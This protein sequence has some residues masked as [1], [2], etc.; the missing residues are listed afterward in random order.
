MKDKNLMGKVRKSSLQSDSR[1]DSLAG[2]RA[3]AAIGIALMHYLANMDESMEQALKE[4]SCLYET[5]IPFFTLFVYMFF[6]LSA[7]SM[8]CGYYNKF[9]VKD[10]KSYFD[11]ERFY[12]KRYCRIW[13]F[14]ALLVCID[15]LMNPSLEEIYEAF[16]DLTLVFNLLPNPEI[17]VI[18]V[19]WFLG[20]I[21]VF[22]MIFPWFIFLLKDKRRAWFAM[23]IALVMHILVREYFLT[24]KFVLESEI[25]CARHNIVFSFPF[26][27]TGGII[28]LYRDVLSSARFTYL[29]LLLAAV[30][31]IFQ[32]AVSPKLFGS[33]ILYLLIL[34]TLWILYAMTGGISIGGLKLLDN[35]VV[36]FIGG[37]SME[38]YLCHMVMFRVIEKLHIETFIVNPHLLYWIFCVIGISLAIVFSYVVKSIIFPLIGKRVPILAFLK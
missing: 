13:P 21:F 9:V 15:V 33:N 29:W 7:F 32:F 27:M 26:L 36:N 10:G 5:A 20:T 23:A 24:E 14:F 22:Y 28:Y 2:M 1:Y 34:F 11:T 25:G 12:L 31:T 4:S 18:G 6:I 16:S 35:K 8:C 37:I 30:A 38:I 17:K 19:G 3:I